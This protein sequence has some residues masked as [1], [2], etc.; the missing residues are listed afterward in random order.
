MAFTRLPCRTSNC[1]EIS[2]LVVTPTGLP[3][4]THLQQQQQ[5]QQQQQEQLRRRRQEA[6]G[7]RRKARRRRRRAARRGHRMPHERVER[8]LGPLLARPPLVRVSQQPPHFFLLFPVQQII[9]PAYADKCSQTVHTIWCSSSS[10]SRALCN[11]HSTRGGLGRTLSRSRR[12][13]NDSALA[14][15]GTFWPARGTS[16]IGAFMPRG[17]CWSVRSVWGPG[18]HLSRSLPVLK[19]ALELTV[20]K[21][22]AAPPCKAQA[23]A[24][25]QV[26]GKRMIS[27]ATL[28]HRGFAEAAR[29]ADTGGDTST[30]RRASTQAAEQWQRQM[31]GIYSTGSWRRQS[32]QR[33][34]RQQK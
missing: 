1:G 16:A 12:S 14:L 8:L 32:R 28:L 17:C 24:S 34:H 27:V 33:R 19:L 2:E 30:A 4:N 26:V 10:A 25:Q 7:R 5:Q 18:Q 29:Q 20:R 31:A 3:Q 6:R 11:G 21:L 23:Q 15:S 9:L 13:K 22:R